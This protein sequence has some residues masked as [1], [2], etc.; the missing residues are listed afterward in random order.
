MST[1]TKNPPDLAYNI[2]GTSS[3]WDCVDRCFRKYR[4][5]PSKETRATL[6]GAIKNLHVWA[7]EL[8]KTLPKR[9]KPRYCYQI[10][11]AHTK[12]VIGHCWGDD[13]QRD[14][15]AEEPGATFRRISNKA[16][17]AWEKRHGEF[18]ERS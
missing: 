17:K 9:A 11:G 4:H 2:V 8:L 1:R 12:K 5:A 6:H 3:A 18:G 16:L 13:G 7:G 10:I 14:V 15:L